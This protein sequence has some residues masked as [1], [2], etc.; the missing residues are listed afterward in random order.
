[1]DKN[2]REP[3]ARVA[4]NKGDRERDNAIL[5]PEEQHRREPE[6]S[7]AIYV[8]PKIDVSKLRRKQGTAVADNI[9]PEVPGPVAWAI[10]A[11]AIDLAFNP[12]DEA[13]PS[14]TII[15]KFQG[16]LF[17]LIDLI[18]VIWNDVLEVAHYRQSKDEYKR[19]FG[20][21]RP[22]QSDWLRSLLLSTARWQKS[23]GGTN[24][25]KITEIAL[26]ETD[27]RAEDDGEGLGNLD[28]WGKE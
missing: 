5:K 18:D 27:T 23:I 9:V 16:R 24:L 14:F 15:D 3:V 26:A 22:K 8:K 19:L 13:L 20:R 1:M 10:Q 28:A 11:K 21:P 2:K 6:R 7:E 25:T 4:K 17:P 12:S